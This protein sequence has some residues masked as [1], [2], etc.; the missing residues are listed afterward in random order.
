MCIFRIERNENRPHYVHH[1][2]NLLTIRRYQRWVVVAEYLVLVSDYI[3][4]YIYVMYTD[5]ALKQSY[6]ISDS[7]KVFFCFFND[8][9]HICRR[10]HELFSLPAPKKQLFVGII[11]VIWN[12]LF[13]FYGFYCIYLH[14]P[15][16]RHQTSVHF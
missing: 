1:P 10:P 9:D 12:W 15:N 7:F 13:M 3:I 5:S 4:H 11:F 2:L 6:Y 16:L 14:L 8:I